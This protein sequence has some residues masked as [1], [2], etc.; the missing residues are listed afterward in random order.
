MLEAGTNRPRIDRTYPLGD[1]PKALRR[2]GDG[3]VTGKMV[4]RVV[5]LT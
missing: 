2:L 4:V 3:E 1:V 5:G